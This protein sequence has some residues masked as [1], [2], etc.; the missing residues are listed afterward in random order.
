MA[1]YC[2]R[3]GTEYTLDDDGDYY[4][5]QC[6]YWISIPEKAKKYYSKQDN[7]LTNDSSYTTEQGCAA[8]GNPAYPKCKTSCPLFDD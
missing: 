4:C 8:C 1:L 3:C 5:P 6:N 2:D 7:Y